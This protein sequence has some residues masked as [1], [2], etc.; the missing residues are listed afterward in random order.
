MDILVAIAEYSVYFS[1][2]DN[3]YRIIYLFTLICYHFICYLCLLSQP[4]YHIMNYIGQTSNKV[5]NSPLLFCNMKEHP[6]NKTKTIYKLETKFKQHF[7]FI[8]MFS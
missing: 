1:G 3:C 4:L 5:T 7:V 2:V 8:F 6:S